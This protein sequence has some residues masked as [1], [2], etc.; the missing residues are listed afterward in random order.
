MEQ[1]EA[2]VAKK[3]VEASDTASFIWRL[4]ILLAILECVQQATA[5]T[6]NDK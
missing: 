2:R 5:T 3:E 4:L 6:Y 1:G